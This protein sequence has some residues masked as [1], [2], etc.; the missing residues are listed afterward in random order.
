MKQFTD[1]LN[2]LVLR[3]IVFLINLIPLKLAQ[4]IASFVGLLL[5]KILKKRRLATLNNLREAFK[6]EK[7]EEEIVRIAKKSFQNMAMIAPEFLKIRKLAFRLREIMPVEKDKIVWDVLAEKRG[8][9]FLIFHIG[10]WDFLGVEAARM[11][12]PISAIGRPLKNPYVYNYVRDTRA[13]TGMKNIDKDGALKDAIRA[14][15]R[16]ECVAVLCDQN[17]GARHPKVPFF[18]RP[19]HTFSTPVTLALQTNSEIVPVTCIRKGWGKFYCEVHNPVA[20]LRGE[21]TEE[22]LFENMKRM[23]E[24][25]EHIIRKNPDQWLWMH[26]RWKL[27]R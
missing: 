10:N 16:A 7:S 11:G 22:L 5:Y 18:G 4:R 21:K 13:I 14:L 26:N 20:L 3:V 6:S 27:K 23:N 8:V 19:A 17:A 12:F 9:V 24:A 1:Y 2:Y 15:R 25:I